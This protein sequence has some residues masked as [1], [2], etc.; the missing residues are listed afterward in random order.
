MI[1]SKKIVIAHR[2]Y[3]SRYP[4]NT[5][6]AF[7]KALG[8]ADMIELDV[9]LTRDRLPVVIHDETLD[10]TT[11][12]HGKISGYYYSEIKDL[13][14]GSWFA[15]EFAS[16]RIPLLDEVAR[17]IKLNNLEL[18]I[19]IKPEAL[20]NISCDSVENRVLDIIFHYNI[21]NKIVISSFESEFLKRIRISDKNLRLAFLMD[22]E[23]G[24]WQNFC[25]E[26]NCF[27]INP[28]ESL[29]DRKFMQKARDAGVRVIPYTVNDRNRMEELLDLGVDGMF[30]NYPE[31]LQSLIGT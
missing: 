10:R 8:V 27:F 26:M 7:A 14:A 28:N 2:G 3:S 21:Q 12:G 11:N 18:N 19:E 4:E 6:I 24:D 13:D 17:F 5:M 16:Q 20:G 29:V 25:R 15:A 9:T 22:S 23:T 30:T 31:M 1:G